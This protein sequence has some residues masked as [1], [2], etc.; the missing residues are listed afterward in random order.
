M[1]APVEQCYFR[2]MDEVFSINS[3][4]GEAPITTSATENLKTLIAN[5][6][7]AHF[8]IEGPAETLHNRIRLTDGDMEIND[9]HPRISDLRH[10]IG[11]ED[12]GRDI[13][14]A[15]IITPHE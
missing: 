2:Y 15:I 6:M 7:A 1:P 14:H 4:P 3:P 9:E 12:A 11:H 5:Y 10:F 8:I 13:A